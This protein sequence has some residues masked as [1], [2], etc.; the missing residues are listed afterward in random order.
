[1]GGY[2][3]WSTR[4]M[5]GIVLLVS[6]IAKLRGRREFADFTSWLDQ[7]AVVPRHLVRPAAVTMAA[8]EATAAALLAFPGTA[9]AGLAATAAVVAVFAASMALISRRGITAPCRC[10][11]VSTRPMGPAH[12]VRDIVLALLVVG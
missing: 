6:V 4:V 5:L 1:M 10:F 11:G 2:L 8:A 3:I 9:A 7:L 12:L